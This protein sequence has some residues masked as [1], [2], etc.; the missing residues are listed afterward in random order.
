MKIILAT[1]PIFP[2][3]TGIGR[4]TLELVKGLTVAPQ[5]EE[6]KCYNMGRWQDPSS[7]LAPTT[8]TTNHGST[9]F[10]QVRATLAKSKTAVALYSRITPLIEQLRLSKLTDHIYHSP[11]F[12]LPNFNGKSIATFHDL[13]I[14][15]YPEFHPPARVRFMKEQIPKALANADRILTISNY[16]ANEIA[17]HFNYPLEKI[18]VTTLG[19]SEHY[20]PRKE[21]ELAQVLSRY[22]LQHHSYLLSVATLEPRKN[23]AAL[24]RVYQQL[25]ESQRQHTPLVLCGAMGW[26]NQQLIQDIRKAE[27]AGWVRHL[28][29]L[30]EEDMPALYSGAKGFLFPSLYEGF[31]LPVL[32]AFACGCPVVT[33]KA[34]A[35]AELAGNAALLI[36]PHE[37]ED[38][39]Q[40]ILRILEGDPLEDTR[41]HQAQHIAALH[42]WEHCI[43]KTIAAYQAVA[44][45]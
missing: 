9:R 39:A 11:N 28:G 3:L 34:S 15:H 14:F 24:L 31:G 44:A 25:P 6:I 5:I 26:N 33:S 20:Y 12:F 18:T 35:L 10:G 8:A 17:E 37:D 27:A 23:I 4:Y 40:A 1:D 19:V 41:R 16:V 13:S 21:D 42:T 29:Y 22:Q 2:P 38:I 32:E 43:A 36:D 7:I 45:S 30:P